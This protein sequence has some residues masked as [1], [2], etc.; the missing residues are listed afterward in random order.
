M[1]L[2]Q[3]HMLLQGGCGTFQGH[4]VLGRLGLQLRV[5]L[6]CGETAGG[7]SGL[8]PQGQGSAS[9]PSWLPGPCGTEGQGHPATW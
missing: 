3:V 2:A 8:A 1:G 5:H 9:V 4:Q 6:D 7:W